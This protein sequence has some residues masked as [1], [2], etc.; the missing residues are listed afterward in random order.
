MKTYKKT[1]KNTKDKENHI[2]SKAAKE[3][4]DN[5]LIYSDLNKEQTIQKKKKD[6]IQMSRDIAQRNWRTIN[7]YSRDQAER[8][9]RAFLRAGYPPEQ[10]GRLILSLIDQLGYG[11]QVFAHGRGG[12]DSGTQGDTMARITACVNALVNWANNNPKLKE[13]KKSSRSYERKDKDGDDKD[14]GGGDSTGGNKELGT[15]SQASWITGI[16]SWFA[17][18]TN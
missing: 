16:P 15:G 7:Q 4:K 6:P 10:A 3:L 2:P 5:R 12:S 18:K 14:K 8:A 9:D 11:N 17:N 13:E 1:Q